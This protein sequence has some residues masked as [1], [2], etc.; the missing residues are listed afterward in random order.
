MIGFIVLL[1]G[2]VSLVYEVVWARLLSVH[3]GSTTEGHTVVI[4]TFMGGLGLGYALL[5]RLSDRTERPL[6]L[7]ALLEV[8][9]TLWAF[10]LPSL[11]DAA[12]VHLG[13]GLLLA[14]AAI[15]VPTTLMGGTLPALTAA[16]APR[17]TPGPTIAGLYGL[18]ALGAAL[19]VIAAGFWM[20]EAHGVRGAGFAA[21]SLNG[22][23]ALTAWQIARRVRPRPE[24]SATPPVAGS[25]VRWA[26]LSAGVV[27][28]ASMALQ[29]AW[30]RLFAVVLGSSSYSFSLVIGVYIA[31]MAL[32]SLLVR[33]WADRLPP[34]ATLLGVLAGTCACFG[35]SLR[36]FLHFGRFEM[37][38]G[39]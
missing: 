11:V 27:G 15:A 21:A 31:G 39:V 37:G 20:I 26:C 29:G 10:A 22:L 38:Q 8:G 12:S 23:L 7:Y 6:R 36:F 2:A 34:L 4:A 18:N 14:I 16:L 9:I 25:M 33:R 28:F 17:D 30:I 13:G 35:H 24:V 19:G 5:G 3:L 1:S 32:G